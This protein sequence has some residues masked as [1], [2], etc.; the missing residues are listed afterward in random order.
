MPAILAFFASRAGIY[1]IAAVI[2]GGFLI[3]IRQA[4]YNSA[5]RKCEAAAQQREIE[6]SRRDA[7]IGQER[8]REAARISSDLDKAEEAARDAQRKLEDELSKRPASAQCN[9]TEPDRRRLQ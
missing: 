6:I 1:L 8:E 3:G 9:L 5:M 7:A 2:A 4:G